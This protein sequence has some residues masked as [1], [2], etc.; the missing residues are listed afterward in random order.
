MQKS[1]NEVPFARTTIVAAALFVIIACSAPAVRR[2]ALRFFP[3]QKLRNQP[4]SERYEDEDGTAT[5]ESEAAY[6]YQLP[7]VLVL[8]LSVACLLDSLA[9]C[10]ITTQSL[11]ST[12][13]VEQWLQFGAWVRSGVP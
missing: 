2:I 8:L 7:R 11:G 12:P 3:T 10:V 6:S 5:Q 1:H 9:L 4:L 13:R